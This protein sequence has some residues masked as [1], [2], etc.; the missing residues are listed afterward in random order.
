[1]SS[2][3]YYFCFQCLCLSIFA[4]TWEQSAWTGWRQ[5]TMI[6]PTDYNAGSVCAM[7]EVQLKDKT[8]HTLYCL[9]LSVP[10]ALRLAAAAFGSSNKTMHIPVFLNEG[11]CLYD[12]DTSKMEA[13]LTFN[14][15]VYRCVQQFAM[16]APLS[17]LKWDG[18]MILQQNLAHRDLSLP[19]V[20][21]KGQT[22]TFSDRR[23]ESQN[24]TVWSVYFFS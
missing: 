9:V 24:R 1:M 13:S 15:I 18:V 8:R 14:D 20:C 23:S 2:R 11:L 4:L 6:I 12:P 19:L 10:V 17:Q 3:R 7:K 22:H 21:S 5:F 16:N